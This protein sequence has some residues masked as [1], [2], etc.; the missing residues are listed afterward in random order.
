M[1]VHAFQRNEQRI[2]LMTTCERE[3]NIQEDGWEREGQIEDDDDDL[4]LGRL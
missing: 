3:K 2:C 1:S 4:M